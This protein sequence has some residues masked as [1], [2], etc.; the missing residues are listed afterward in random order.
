MV[1]YF[2]RLVNNSEKN[3]LNFILNFYENIFR[4]VN[5]LNKFNWFC[6]SLIVKNGLVIDVG[7]FFIF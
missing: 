6:L 5:L 2:I 3:W 4:L 1:G 7:V